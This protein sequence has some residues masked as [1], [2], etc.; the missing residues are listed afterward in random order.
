MSDERIT[1]R[2]S[3]D[4]AG[5][6]KPPAPPGGGAPGEIAQQTRRQAPAKGDPDVAAGVYGDPPPP[7][8]VPQGRMPGGVGGVCTRGGT[9][10]SNLP[11]GVEGGVPD[12]S[13]TGEGSTNASAPLPPHIATQADAMLD[14][15]VFVLSRRRRLEVA[16]LL[17]G[18]GITLGEVQQLAE[19]AARVAGREGDDESSARYLAATLAAGADAV[20]AALADIRRHESKPRQAKKEEPGRTIRERD[21]ERVRR[22]EAEWQAAK[23]RGECNPARRDPHPWERQAKPKEAEGL[24]P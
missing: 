23:A 22:F 18:G 15:G 3:K 21:M 17:A 6:A 4:G 20:R 2:S 1:R 5:A 19:S 13:G 12:S 14:A 16:T 9:G 8:A 11:H 7:R 10:A 24:N